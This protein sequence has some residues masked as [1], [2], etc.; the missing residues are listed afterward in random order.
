MPKIIDPTGAE[1]RLTRLIRWRLM[2]R[3]RA[4]ARAAGWVF[5]SIRRRPGQEVRHVQ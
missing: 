3:Q 2:Q 5:R 4:E 1:D